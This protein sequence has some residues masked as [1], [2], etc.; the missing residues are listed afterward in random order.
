[1]KGK[2]IAILSETMVAAALVLP[3]MA[4]PAPRTPAGL[5]A[6]AAGRLAA[7]EAI[8]AATPLVD[9]H[10]DLPW[11]LQR[12]FGGDLEAV[13]LAGGT[14]ALERPLHTDIPRLRAGG[15]G[16]QFWSVWVPHAPGPES[17]F[18]ALEQ[19][20]VVHRMAA[21]YPETFEIARSAGDITRIHGAGR[22][23]SLIALEGGSLM[24]DSLA[25]LRQLHALGARSL[26]LTHNTTLS[27]ADAAT[28]R[29]AHGGLTEF[30]REVVRELNRLGMLVDLAHVSHDTMRAALEVSAAPVIFSHSSA[31]ALCRHPR[32][33]PDDVLALL[34]ANGGVA[35]VTFVPSFVSEEV[36]LWVADWEAEQARQRELFPGDHQ[37]AEGAVASWRA[38][39][40]P[41]RATLEQV[42]DH[43]DHVRAVAGIEHVGIGSDFDGISSTP[44]GLEDV[45]AFPA[46]LAELLGRGYSPEE[47]GL[48]AGGNLLRVMRRAEAVAAGMVPSVPAG[49]RTP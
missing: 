6:E 18:G 11:V 28:D 43:I 31:F 25:I 16:A 8:L 35:M 37:A 14:G 26:I 17:V 22:I 48:V 1:M 40:P 24:G 46:L 30:G 44:T 34:P 41:P 5:E 36:R 20:D 4:G 38:A 15:V 27:W 45:S 29:P 32:N 21:R 3:A 23:A 49:R 9:G 13:D 10:N 12:R 39:N 42:A 7:V 47:V 33:V 19:I 2:W